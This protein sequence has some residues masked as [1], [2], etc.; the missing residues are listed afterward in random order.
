M[1]QIFIS[2]SRKDEHFRNFFSKAFAGTRVK[3]IF[4]EL[5]KIYRGF[6]NSLSVAKAIKDSKAVFIILSRNVQNIYFTRDWI[7]WEAGV[8]INKDIWVFEPYSQFGEISVVIPYVRHYVLDTND[9]YLRF[10]YNII[11]SNPMKMI[12]YYLY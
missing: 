11:S 4:E 1:A 12:M 5:E 9:Y 7:V 2:H 3:A 6:T 10:I 8:A